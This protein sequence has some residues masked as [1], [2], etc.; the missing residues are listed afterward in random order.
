MLQ[1]LIQCLPQRSGKWWI[2]ANPYNFLSICATYPCSCQSA[3]FQWCSDLSRSYLRH[4]PFPTI[5][6]QDER[7]AYTFQSEPHLELIQIELKLNLI[8]KEIWLP[9]T[10]GSRSTKRA[11]GT[12]FP[13][14]VSEK[15]VLKES[16]PSPTVR[17][18]GI[19]PSGWIPCSKQYN[20]QQ[21]LPIWTPAWP[22]WI[23]I[24]S[25][26]PMI[27]N[28]VLLKT[29]SSRINFKNANDKRDRIR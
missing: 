9:M 2:L 4:L 19:C 20:S 23:E 22:T 10:L 6:D 1:D 26:I 11:R 3:L 14:P 13:V 16:M 21:A 8:F 15:K 29:D 24:T 28:L 18:L 27:K 12:C 5:I 7:V 17:S 25:L